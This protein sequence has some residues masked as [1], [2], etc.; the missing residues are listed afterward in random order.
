[1]ELRKQQAY[2]QLKKEL[3]ECRGLGT[4]LLIITLPGTGM[5]RMI[6]EYGVDVGESKAVV[7]TDETSELGS[8]NLINF[9]WADTNTL[10]KVEKI[11]KKA[12][13]DQ[14]IAITINYPTLL[15][16]D[17][18]LKSFFINHTYRKYYFGLRS[19]EDSSR[20]CREINSELSKEEISNIYNLSGGLAQLIKYLV[21]NGTEKKDGAEIILAPVVR[22]VVGVSEEV[23]Q[24]L[25]IWNKEGW[26]GELLKAYNKTVKGI[27]IQINF[28]LSFEEDGKLNK[29]KLTKS[30]KQLLEKFMVNNGKLTKEEVS[31]IKWGEGKYDE[32]SDQAINK[33]LRRLSEKLSIYTIQTIPKVGFIIKKK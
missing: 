13:T 23:L 22:A 28:D 17:N 12:K 33:Q 20:L 24:K 7:I 9:D 4:N 3:D 15:N 29:Q 1:M 19:E 31:D 21:V 18:L 16:D 30:E 10:N 14:K 25:G 32:F 6:K 11:F 2:I 5:G 8:Y 27:D 26:R